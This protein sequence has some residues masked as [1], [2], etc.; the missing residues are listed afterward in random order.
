MTIITTCTLCSIHITINHNNDW[1]Y[2]I[3]VFVF[4]VLKI[5]SLCNMV[6]D[7]ILQK[8]VQVMY[9]YVCIIFYLLGL[10][11]NIDYHGQ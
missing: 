9:S 1:K 5:F 8:L 11:N 6:D 10:G 4:I 3:L 7:S 2:S